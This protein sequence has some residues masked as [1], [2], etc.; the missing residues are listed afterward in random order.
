VLLLAAAIATGRRA[1]GVGAVIAAL[2]VMGSFYYW[3]GWPLTDKAALMFAAGVALGVLCWTT[4]VHRPALRSSRAAGAP[5]ALARG[6]VVLG[7][8]VTGGLA[9]QA[10]TTNETIIANGR[11]IFV[12]LAPVDPRSLI[13]GDYMRLNFAVPGQQRRR[14][15]AWL[16]GQRRWA[17]ATVDDRQVA[18][19]ERVVPELPASI[20]PGQLVLP[21]RYK[22][23]RWIVS[24]D[25]WFFKEGTAQKWE[26]ARFGVFRVGSD[27]TALLVGMADET[28]A[29]IQ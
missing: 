14:D 21:L 20:A 18:T 4:G 23:R 10:I 19:I 6:L 16:L 29:I 26:Q 1:M 17:I 2:W 25:A 7:A 15:D 8:L 22:D 12:A 11:Q 28:L 3:L 9:T 24:T 5:P 27:G 13:Q